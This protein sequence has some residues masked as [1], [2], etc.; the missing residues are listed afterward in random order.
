MIKICPNC[1]A[2]VKVSKKHCDSI[3]SCKKCK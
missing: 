3:R 2:K 1:G